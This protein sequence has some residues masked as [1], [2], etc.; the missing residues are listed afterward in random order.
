MQEERKKKQLRSKSFCIDVSAPLAM[1]TSPA[2]KQNCERISYPY[3]TYSALRA[4][5]DR[6]YFRPG[7]RWIIDRC[8]I[9]NAI[10]Y[11][12]RFLITPSYRMKQSERMRFR[13]DYL[14]NVRYKVEA[15]YKLDSRF[16]G[17]KYYNINHD[18]IIDRAICSGDALLW[19]GTSDCPALFFPTEFDE[20]E[21]YYDGSGRTDPVRM[22]YG[23]EFRSREKSE[24][25]TV[26]YAQ[27]TM[28][29][30]VIDFR[31]IPRVTF[32]GGL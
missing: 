22:F 2:S 5:F 14:S 23:F 7:I 27:V 24:I 8:R 18:K 9:M 12:N 26:S 28:S 25:K 20:D 17:S 13:F 6:I 29:D 21:G 15:H 10:E 4:M 3:P 31:N 32:R 19:A 11:E 16:F 1:F 30:G